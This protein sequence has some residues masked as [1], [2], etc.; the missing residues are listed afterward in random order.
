MQIT[1]LSRS[2]AVGAIA[3]LSFSACQKTDIVPSQL[4]TNEIS[5]A[6]RKANGQSTTS[7]SGDCGVAPYT[8][9]LDKK[10]NTGGNTWTWTW[11]VSNPMPG[12]GN[13]NTVQ[14]LSHW[15]FT[16][17]SCPVISGATIN[18]IQSAAYSSDSV[19]WNSFTPT[20]GTDPSISGAGITDSVLKFDF[21]TAGSSKS[22]YRVVVS[23]DFEIENTCAYFKSGSK[24]GV[25]TATIPGMGCGG[26]GGE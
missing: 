13:G 11:T 15:G 14:N 22:Y 26:G 9:T 2:L 20:Y 17:K 21:G 3:L 1:I 16:F 7:L 19:N 12:N 18:D 4:S 24:T 8:V 5:A 25:R 6:M 10:C 23:R